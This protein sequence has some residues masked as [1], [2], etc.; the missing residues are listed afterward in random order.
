VDQPLRYILNSVNIQV[1]MTIAAAARAFW[2]EW[3][4]SGY[5][6]WLVDGLSPGRTEENVM[7]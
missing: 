5:I 7:I 6:S 2:G 4:R 1:A 3:L